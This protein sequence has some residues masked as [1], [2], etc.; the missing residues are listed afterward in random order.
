MYFVDMK[1]NKINK[2]FVFCM[3]FVLFVGIIIGIQWRRK[4]L[5]PLPQ[6]KE[7]KQSFNQSNSIKYN[8]KNPILSKSENEEDIFIHI[9]VEYL[10]NYNFDIDKVGE[11]KIYTSIGED[12]IIVNSNDIALILID[13]WGYPNE[14]DLPDPIVK[15][16]K[17]CSF[18]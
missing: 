2:H 3:I 14:P 18:F 1:K 11:K 6:L 12:T 15:K 10:P 13:T 16:Q 9:P 7:W 8:Y 4:F 17:K 5:F